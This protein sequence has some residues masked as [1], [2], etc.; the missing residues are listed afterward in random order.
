MTVAKSATGNASTRV[1]RTLYHKSN[2]IYIASAAFSARLGGTRCPQRVG[3]AALPPDLCLR[4]CR[5]HRLED[6]T[7][8]RKFLKFFFHPPISFYTRRPRRSLFFRLIVKSWS[9]SL[10]LHWSFRPHRPICFRLRDLLCPERRRVFDSAA[11]QRL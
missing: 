9:A 7:I 1:I 6:K 5:C 11:R 2:R 8:H 4:R 3:N 10:L